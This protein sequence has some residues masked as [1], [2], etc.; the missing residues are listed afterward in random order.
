MEVAARN[1]RKPARGDPGKDVV[2]VE[3]LDPIDE[4]RKLVPLAEEALCGSRR[5]GI[6]FVAARMRRDDRGPGSRAARIAAAIPTA[7]ETKL[8]RPTATA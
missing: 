2:P 4:R 3:Q 8:R 7:G 6:P 1:G 5:E